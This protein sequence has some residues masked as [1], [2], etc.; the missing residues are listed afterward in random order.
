MSLTSRINLVAIQSVHWNDA[1]GSAFLRIDGSSVTQF[2]NVGSGVVNCQYYKQGDDPTPNIGEYEVFELI[3]ILL[4]DDPV[5]GGNLYGFAI[6]SLNFPSAFLRIDGSNV[7]GS[8]GGGVGTVNCQYYSSGQ[9]PDWLDNPGQYEVF[10]LWSPGEGGVENYYALQSAAFP[11]I[12]LRMDGSATM[13]GSA[14]G[15][16]GFV[17]GQWYPGQFADGEYTG[18]INPPTSAGTYETLNVVLL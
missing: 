12:F 6:R 18:V 13:N 4:S 17:N 8:N 11:N 16:S 14:G 1:N 5:S 3:P 9:Y 7:G 15:G 2:N 10:Q